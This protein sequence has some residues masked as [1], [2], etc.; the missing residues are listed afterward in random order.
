MGK[1]TVIPGGK[2]AAQRFEALVLAHYDALYRVAYRFTRSSHDAEDLVQEVCVRAVPR[3]DELERLEQPRGWLMRV[4]YRL[5]VDLSRRYER[6][7][8]ASLETL[9]AAAMPSAE[10]D[11]ADGAAAAQRAERLD[12][13][14]QRLDKEQRALLAL[15]DI[16]G[17]SLRELNELTGLKE[18]TL[19]SRLHRARA[20]LGAFLQHEET[21]SVALLAARSGGRP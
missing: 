6:R 21:A 9:D 18:G 15:H 10:H 5:F 12:R 8:V 14:W 1:L 13:A 19:K 17:Y 11:A 20:R 2:S 4:L 16:E 7:H 3:L